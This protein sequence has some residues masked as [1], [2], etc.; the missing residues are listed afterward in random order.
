MKFFHMSIARS[1]APALFLTSTIIFSVAGV[2]HAQYG[3]SGQGGSSAGSSSGQSGSTGASSGQG[4]STTRSDKDKILKDDMDMGYVDQEK[5]DER[6]KDSAS[7]SKDT[8]VP[9]F[10]VDKEG[11]PLKDLSKEQGGS[12][13]P[14]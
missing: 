14:N 1:L 4:S 6:N 9:N 13:G 3:T 10:P 5:R 2:A 11:R 12:I 7:P 8:H